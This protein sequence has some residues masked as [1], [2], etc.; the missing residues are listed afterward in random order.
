[1]KRVY[2]AETLIDGQMVMDLLSVA[3][4]PCLLFNENMVGGLGELPVTY[5]EVWV[6]ND[7][8]QAKALGLIDDFENA[9]PPAT[10]KPCTTCGE[11][12][13]DTFDVCWQCNTGL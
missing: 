1:M 9:P 12:N 10:N 4:I 8:D 11:Y 5:P 6:Q 2:T 13:P 7:R 3:G